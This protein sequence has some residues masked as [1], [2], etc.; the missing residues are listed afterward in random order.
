[1]QPALGAGSARPAGPRRLAQGVSPGRAGEQGLR[2]RIPP[3]AV[4]GY[5]RWDPKRIAGL[6]FRKGDDEGNMAKG[7][8]GSFRGNSLTA[9]DLQAMENHELRLDQSGHRRSVRK[10][11]KGDPIPPLIHNPL[12]QNCLTQA[13]AAHVEGARVN[14]GASKICRHAFVQFPT[15]LPVTSASEQMMLD[16]AVKFVN[17]T[18]G[19]NA[20]FWARLDRDEVGRHG[21][22]VFFAP[23]YE[24]TT[25][26]GATIWISL[27]K[28]GKARAVERFG[29]RQAVKKNPKTGEFEKVTDKNGDPVMVDCDSKYFQ[30]RAFQDLWFEHLRDNIGLDWVE[31]GKPKVGR[32]PD[33]LEVEEFKVQQ[34]RKKLTKAKSDLAKISVATQVAQDQA[35]FARIAAEAY[36][37]RAQQ[38]L[39]RE[40]AA[41][42]REAAIRASIAR[43][44]PLRTEE[45]E[46]RAS[47]ERLRLEGV[48]LSAALDLARNLYASVTET[49]R[50]VVPR[51][52]NDL[53]ARIDQAWA[54]DTKRNPSAMPTEPAPPESP[55]M[56]HK[57]PSDPS[58]LR[59]GGP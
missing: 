46:L 27:T 14:K 49:I 36:E 35:A 17:K 59:P 44:E 19:G 16:E 30:G 54:T 23:K 22:D 57:A 52:A 47:V 51:I 2:G 29:Q 40:K 8:S 25:K 20:V 21:V 50:R 37:E 13:Y 11:A 32:D 7:K 28:F 1:M 31:R 42:A 12:R 38:A 24:K 43:M 58:D 6:P 15:D 56:R 55:L 48:R 10:D 9:S 5:R 53:I 33:R 26:R 18:H 39:E 45:A 34:E 41:Q 4:L 3:P